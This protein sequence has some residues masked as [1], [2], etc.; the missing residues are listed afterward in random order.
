MDNC[1]I[2][3]AE[4][5]LRAIRS[6][7]TEI[8]RLISPQTRLMAVVK[9]NAYGH[10]MVEVAKA[11]LQEGAS[12]LGVATP[13]EAVALREAGINA[14][15]LILGYMPEECA[16][17]LVQNRIEVTVFN[18][19]TAQV[20]SQAA[21]NC[22]GEARLHL[23]I[24]TGMGRLG[25]KPDSSS[26]ELIWEISRLPGIVLQ[27]IFSH[28]ATADHADK[29]FAMQQLEI[30]KS[31]IYKLEESGVSI[32]LKHIANSA[33]IMEMP[34]AHF[35]M[36]RSGITTYGLYPSSQ[37]DKGKLDLTP[38]MRLKSRIS[39]VKTIPQG[40]SVSYG[41][42]YIS[43]HET[44]VATVSIGYADGYSRLLSNRGW[45]TI[46]GRKVPLIGTVCMDQ[47]M[48]DVSGIE[49]VQVGDEIILFG[50]PEDGV[51][52]DDLADTIGTINYEIVCA[53]SSRVN[54]IYLG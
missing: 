44:R 47:C 6:N 25:F 43:G 10:G 19:E 15:V 33:A 27:G 54:R 48:F 3:W 11:C 14:Q 37:V 17:T 22:G 2:S 20:L 39:Y 34:E 38:A 36:V 32:P 30:F 18:L 31:F 40:Q 24:D 35:D 7:I 1:I 29:S 53:P 41:R 8:K 9:A 13:N 26:L 28:L 45:A 51:T 46:R 4:I 50:R 52:A 42:T 12:Y 5:D 49:N 21:S 16:E 23:K